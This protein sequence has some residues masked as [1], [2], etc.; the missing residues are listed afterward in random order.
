M[1]SFQIFLRRAGDHG[2]G[3]LVCGS[4]VQINKLQLALR[5]GVTVIALKTRSWIACLYIP[6]VAALPTLLEYFVSLN[7]VRT[8]KSHKSDGQTAVMYSQQPAD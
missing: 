2:D 4:R 5:A 7:Q 8:A 6:P 3:K 1:G